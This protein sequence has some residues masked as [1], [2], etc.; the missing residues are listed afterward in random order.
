MAS[1]FRT[2]VADQPGQQPKPHLRVHAVNVFVRDQEEALRFYLD[3]L[4]FT[5]AYD[6]RLQSGQRWMGVAPPDGSAVL[7][8][9]APEPDSEQYQLIG[10]PTG[11]VFVTEDITSKYTAWRKRGVKFHHTPRLR[12]MKYEHVHDDEHPTVLQGRETPVW[13][14]V[15]TRFEDLDGN[16]FMLISIDEMTQAV[17]AQRRADEER[18]E[19]ARRTAHEMEIARQVQARLFPQSLPAMKSLDYAGA[20]IQAREVGG[21]YYDFLPLGDEGLGLVLGDVAGKGIAGALL[22]A[23]LQANLRSQCAVARDEPRRLLRSVNQLFYENTTDNTYATLFFAQYDDR[24]QRMRYINCGHLPALVLR[25][26]RSV[27]RLESTCTVLGLFNEWDCQVRE[28]GLSAGDML[29]IY[30]DGVTEALN[31]AEEEFGEERL[32]NVL[33]R[34]RDRPAGDVLAA[35]VE[36]VRG[37]STGEQSDDITLVAARCQS[38]R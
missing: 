12:R 5:L 14:S 37:H 9:V 7:T 33:D 2:G 1:P 15:F 17:E 10:R 29:A 3:K 6:I 25:R 26:D 19:T 24:T 38:A 28:I 23:N 4:E 11:I 36:A 34:H 13:G 21:D 30:T 22:M 32:V 20:C 18:R 27:V 31:S 16:S 8:L 35:V